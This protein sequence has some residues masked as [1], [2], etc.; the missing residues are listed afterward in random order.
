MT[1]IPVNDVTP[2]QQLVDPAGGQTIF[3]YPFR[4]LADADLV[5][6]QTVVATGAV[7]LLTLTTDYTVSG[8]GDATGGTI[9]LVSGTAIGDIITMWRDIAVQRLNDYP[10]QGDFKADTLNL[11]LDTMTLVEQ[12]LERD[13]SR[14]LHLAP[15][16]VTGSMEIPKVADRK[17]KY[18][19]FDSVTGSPAAAQNLDGGSAVI[20][21]AAE[22]VLDDAT[23]KDMRNTLGVR[24]LIGVQVFTTSG[25]WTM[26][27]NTLSVEIICV[28]G[29]GGSGGADATSGAAPLACTG[30][31]GGGGSYAY[32]YLD[33]SGIGAAETVTVGAAGIQGSAAGGNGGAGGVTTFGAHVNAGGGN[34]GSGAVQV[35]GFRNGQGGAGGVA[36]TGAIK[37]NGGDGGAGL[38]VVNDGAGYMFAMR[39]D[40]GPSAGGFGGLRKVSTLAITSQN[41]QANGQAGYEY[42]GGGIGAVDMGLTNNPAQGASGGGGRA[43]IVIV[44]SYG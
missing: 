14:S 19:F 20:T 26:P 43:G 7:N 28:G 1:D 22:T 21:P 8:A 11:E 41:I 24:G 34:G 27:A 31:G 33:A 2:R 39:G 3:A 16:D 40:G 23:V 6:E 9:T 37:I 36:A 35:G 13:I 15:S 18:L 4:I 30:G 32:N 42:G 10:V 38:A 25:T 17:G 29:G 12:Q 5:V 44:K